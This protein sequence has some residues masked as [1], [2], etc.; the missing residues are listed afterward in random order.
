MAP[1]NDER[2]ARRDNAPGWFT[3][4]P[5]LNT[6]ERQILG[7]SLKWDSPVLRWCLENVAIHTD[8]AGNRVMHKGKSRDRIDLAVCLW[9][10][11]SRAAQADAGPSIL[12]SDDFNPENFFI[13]W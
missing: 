6:L 2:P 11:V 1:L 7:R 12:E 4:S 8:T 9:M 3:Q 13:S 10:A 5:A